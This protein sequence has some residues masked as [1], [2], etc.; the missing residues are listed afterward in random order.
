MQP[1][2]LGYHEVLNNE[3]NIN[4]VQIIN[5]PDSYKSAKKKISHVLV[6]RIENLYANQ[7]PVSSILYVQ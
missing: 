7:S 5:T 3:L 2:K 4:K 6:Q 1:I